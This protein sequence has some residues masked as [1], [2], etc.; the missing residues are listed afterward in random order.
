MT[1]KYDYFLNVQLNPNGS[2]YMLTQINR[3][4][5]DSDRLHSTGRKPEYHFKLVGKL[6]TI[7]ICNMDCTLDH[8][9]AIKIASAFVNGDTHTYD[10]E[11]GQWV[12][13]LP[14]AVKEP[15]VY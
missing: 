6:C 1:T 10:F 5:K 3:M 2:R 15:V 14:L 7:Y 8:D 11:I 12:K 13:S 4:R 9:K